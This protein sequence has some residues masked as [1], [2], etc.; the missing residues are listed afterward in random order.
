MEEGRSSLLNEPSI[1][2]RPAGE[3]TKLSRDLKPSSL[4]PRQ[5]RIYKELSKIEIFSQM[6]GLRLTIAEYAMTRFEGEISYV[7]GLHV[8]HVEEYKDPK[9]G[10]HIYFVDFL[11]RGLCHLSSIATESFLAHTEIPLKEGIVDSW[12]QKNVP[13]AMI[14][15]TELWFGREGDITR[16]IGRRFLTTGTSLPPF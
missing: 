3:Q 12:T 15:G 8:D 10:H 6:H 4:R 14:D 11:L 1:L 16:E 7:F 9:G 5:T 2:T 13:F